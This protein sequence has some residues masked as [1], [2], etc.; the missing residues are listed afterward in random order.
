MLEHED[1]GGVLGLVSTSNAQ[2]RVSVYASNIRSWPVHETTPITAVS[3]ETSTDIYLVAWLA[4]Q[5]SS[6]INQ[7]GCAVIECD[8]PT[9]RPGH[10][11]V[12]EAFGAG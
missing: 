12:D 10:V 9:W 5:L 11:D 6:C 3:Q 2:T 1:D 7:G 8:T 4:G